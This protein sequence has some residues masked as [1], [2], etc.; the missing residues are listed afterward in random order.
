M[1][2]F[3]H[4]MAVELLG[5]EFSPRTPLEHVCA[6]GAVGLVFGLACYGA[7]CLA[8]KLWTSDLRGAGS[9]RKREGERAWESRGRSSGP[10]S[11]PGTAPTTLV[12]LTAGALTLC[13]GGRVQR[14]AGTLEFHGGFSRWFARRFGFGAMTLGHVIIARDVTC[15]DTCREHEQAHVRQAEH[16][17]PLFI[18]AYLAASCWAWARGGI[19]TSITSSSATHAAHAVTNGWNV[20][21]RCR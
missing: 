12:G 17:G 11:M 5:R 14:K 2:L 20:H 13:S 7:W 19:T 10:W 3:A 21:D 4:H 1:I 18:P 16:W 15:L 9:I 6:F 8:A